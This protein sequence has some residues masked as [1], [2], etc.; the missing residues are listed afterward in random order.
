MA[1]SKQN[2]EAR[3]QELIAAAKQ[4]NIEVRTE[5]LL[6]EVGYRAHSGRCR[7]M[8]QD[9]ILLDRDAPLGDQIDFLSSALADENSNRA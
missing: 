6:R 4:K 5:K 2:N 3:L 8:G 7:I 9:V 1:R